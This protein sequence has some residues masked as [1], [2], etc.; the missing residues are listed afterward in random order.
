M[1][2][3]ELLDLEHAGW[4]SLCDGTGDRFY[5]S[6]MTDDAVMVLANG[7]VL[8]RAAVT[9]ALGQS[10]PWARY[11]ITDVRVIEISADTAALVYT[12]TAHR[13]GQ[14]EPFVAAME[15]GPVPAVAS[16]LSQ[17]AVAGRPALASFRVG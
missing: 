14:P 4:R 11:D 3:N 16:R 2:T 15:A 17:V 13:D 7:M 6:L 5:G 10:P 9:T 12:G 8:D 1:T